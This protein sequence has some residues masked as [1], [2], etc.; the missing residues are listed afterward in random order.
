LNCREEWEWLHN[1]ENSTEDSLDL[2][3]TQ[4]RNAAKELFVMLGK[5][6]K[7]LLEQKKKGF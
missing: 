7:L 5:K 6:N 1:N 2:F 4:F 3:K